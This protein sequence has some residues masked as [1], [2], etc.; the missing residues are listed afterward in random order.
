MNE[1]KNLEMEMNEEMI[2]AAT[3]KFDDDIKF[4][5]MMTA[6]SLNSLTLN[7][8]DKVSVHERIANQFG[9]GKM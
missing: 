7:P 9:Y 4:S 8:K 2:E 3:K 1:D 6:N 5:E